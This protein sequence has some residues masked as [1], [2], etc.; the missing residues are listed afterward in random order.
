MSFSVNP[1]HVR[2]FANKL[3]NLSKE[4]PEATAYVGQHLDIGYAD[5]RLFAT[6]ASPWK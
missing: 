3:E 5:A 4:A 2:T 1:E 6:I